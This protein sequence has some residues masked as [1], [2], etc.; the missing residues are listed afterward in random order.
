M[1]RDAND[2]TLARNLGE[3]RAGEYLGEETTATFRSKVIPPAPVA[4]G[5]EPS[6]RPLPDGS[7]PEAVE[8]S[9]RF[10]LICAHHFDSKG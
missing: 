9:A 8:S 5:L 6:S 4:Y 1:E 3:A 2:L 10:P 7:A